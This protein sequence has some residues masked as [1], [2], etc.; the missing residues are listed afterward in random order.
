M[1]GQPAFDR[2]LTRNPNPRG[3][4]FQ[5]AHWTRRRFF[6][7]AGAG[8]GGFLLDR[9]YAAAAET[10]AAGALPRRTAKNVI[11]I[12]LAGA[13]SQIDTFDFRMQEGS[14][15]PSFAPETIRG[16]LWP[17]GLLPKLGEQLS[18]F[19]IVRSM[20]SRALV[21]SLCQSWVQIGRNPASTSADIAPHIGSVIAMEKESERLA[22]QKLPTFL[23]FNSNNV[24]GAGYLG[25]HYAPFKIAPE[26]AGI[27]NR[28]SPAG[29]ERFRSRF[30]FLR[31]LDGD[32]RVNSP[33]GTAMEDYGAFYNSAQ[34]MAYDPMIDAAF[35]FSETDSERYGRSSF[36][37][38]C[39]VAY[40]T[41]KSQLGTRFIQITSNDGWDMHTSIYQPQFLPAKGKMLDNGVSALLNDLKSSGLLESTLIVMMGEFGR[42]VAPVAGLR[43]RDHYPQQFAFFA[44]GGVKGGTIIGST[45]SSGEDV[46]D[47]GW[48]RDRYVYAEDVE[49]T[50]Y[51]AMGIDWTTVRHD[52]LG[53]RFEYVPYA[54]QDLYGPVEELW[55]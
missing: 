27:P 33:Y 2:F 8:L 15:P 52:S 1:T 18:D 34:G 5:R 55:G 37:N 3:T 6:E 13:P 51:S 38:A 19:A 50:I 12:L 23:A 32:L 36:G 17:T 4:F 25:A 42:T 35:R 45:T 46:S 41:I 48:S 24:E 26:Q 29:E 39:R 30:E 28:T 54:D 11:F 9:R 21:H 53:Q 47:P 14:T 43:G 16:V 44:G 40:Q 31:S 22:G 7:L 10:R 49:A 20:R